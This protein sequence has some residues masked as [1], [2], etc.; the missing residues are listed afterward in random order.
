MNRK[1]IPIPMIREKGEASMTATM[2]WI[3]F[4]TCIMGQFGKLA[5][6]FGGVDLTQANYLF[7][8]CL[9]AYLGRKLQGDGKKVDIDGSEKPAPAAP[10]TP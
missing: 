9:A 10:P 2:T 7:A 5:G 1:G 6:F 3:S 4:N 8:I